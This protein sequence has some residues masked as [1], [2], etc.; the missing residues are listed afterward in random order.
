MCGGSEK[1]FYFLLQRSVMS[2]SAQFQ[3]IEDWL[4][5]IADVYCFHTGI[6]MIVCW[7]SSFKDDVGQK[8]GVGQDIGNTLASLVSGA[9]RLIDHGLDCGFQDEESAGDGVD[10]LGVVAKPIVVEVG[11]VAFYNLDRFENVF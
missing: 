9:D 1:V 7:V 8:R 5:N 6:I 4:R 2:R 11:S 10:G 3:P